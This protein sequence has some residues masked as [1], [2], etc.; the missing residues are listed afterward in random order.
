MGTAPPGGQRQDLPPERGHVRELD[1]NPQSPVS[2]RRT[3]PPQRAQPGSPREPLPSAPPRPSSPSRPAS[4][5][6]QQQPPLRAPGHTFGGPHPRHIRPLPP[7]GAPEAT[8][9]SPSRPHLE[10]TSWRRPGPNR[11]GGVYEPAFRRSRR[12]PSL[13]PR[14]PRS[15]PRPRRPPQPSR[16]PPRD[17]RATPALFRA[18]RGSAPRDG[19][20]T[21]YR[22]LRH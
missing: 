8:L 11:A 17:P 19:A 6:Q 20:A 5:G 22:Q 1:L 9:A 7:P 2:R 21:P 15:P 3:L 4:A 13:T 16:R 10:E 18:A 12:G 14:G